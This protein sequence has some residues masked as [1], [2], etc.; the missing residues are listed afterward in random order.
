MS[1]RA[2]QFWIFFSKL[3]R[4]VK[5][6]K[7]ASSEV[8]KILEFQLHPYPL[9]PSTTCVKNFKIFGK[10][11]KTFFD[12]F[13]MRL[14][15]TF[16]NFFGFSRILK[17]CLKM[18][19]LFNFIISEDIINKDIFVPSPSPLYTKFKILDFSILKQDF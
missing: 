5:S 16:R 3:G 15:K 19:K 12:F 13:S 14:Q 4:V 17:S 6:C 11:Q 9:P 18:E 8:I 1:T 2:S 10:H 7:M